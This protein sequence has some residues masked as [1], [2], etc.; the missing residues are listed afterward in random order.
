MQ[1]AVL[2]ANSVKIGNVF[3]FEN[4]KKNYLIEENIG[5]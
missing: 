5:F 3:L 1:H 4:P 2:R